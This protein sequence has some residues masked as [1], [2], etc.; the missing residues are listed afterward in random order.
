MPCHCFFLKKFFFLI[1]N[2]LFNFLCVKGV[3]VCVNTKKKI[4][5]NK[6]NK[7]H[8]PMINPVPIAPPMAIIVMCRAFNPR[9]KSCENSRLSPGDTLRFSAPDPACWGCNVVLWRAAISDFLF[10]FLFSF[11]F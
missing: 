11:F 2:F 9:C 8:V 6:K 10:F 7:T 5:K 3:C 1:F 4:K